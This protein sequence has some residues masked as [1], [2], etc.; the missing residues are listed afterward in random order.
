M[1]KQKSK[2]IYVVIGVLKNNPDFERVTYVIANSAVAAK[3]IATAK[4]KDSTFWWSSK[5][6]DSIDELDKEEIE[7][8][9]GR[10]AIFEPES[11][12]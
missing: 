4:V 2:K 12:C 6:A 11:K 3:K 8:F 7:L 9:K 5:L 1:K 10:I